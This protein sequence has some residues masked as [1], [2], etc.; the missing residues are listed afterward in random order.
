M[1]N[2]KTPVLKFW[3]SIFPTLIVGL[4]TFPN[5]AYG[6][7]SDSQDPILF[8]KGTPIFEARENIYEHENGEW[9]NF[10]E[11]GQRHSQI[12]PVEVSGLFLPYDALNNA[13]KNQSHPYRKIFGKIFDRLLPFNDFPSVYDWMSLGYYR[14]QRVGGIERPRGMPKEMRVGAGL[15]QTE[16]GSSLSF[17]CLSCHASQ[18][19]GTTVIGL[20]NKWPKANELFVLAKKAIPLV[21]A[22]LFRIATQGNEKDEA[23]FRRTQKNL[24]RVR[25]IEPIS[26]GVDTSLAQVGRALAT[27]KE[28]AWAEPSNFFERFPRRTVFSK[29]RSDSKPMP[30]WNVK[31]KNRWLADGSVVS[32]N[33]IITNLLWNEIGRG[34]D[35][36]ELEAWMTSNTRVIEE[37][38][39]LVFAN[40]APSY[41]DFA[42]VSRFDLAS[43]KRGEIIFK[44]NC[45]TC[46]GH[47]EKNWNFPEA[48]DLADQVKTKKVVYHEQTP[49]VNVGSEGGRNQ[50]MRDLESPLN[51]LEISQRFEVQIE[52]QEGY[53]PPPLVGIFSR[54]PYL[55]NASIPNLCELLTPANLRVK[56]FY[57]GPAENWSTD[58]DD[59]CVGYPVGRNVPQGW[60]QEKSWQ[61]HTNISGRKSIG[62]DQMLFN[63]NGIEKFSP[64]NKKDLISFLKTL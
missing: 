5:F 64:Q 48:S 20:P 19:F 21:P 8:A 11:A 1:P 45:S 32:G 34:T 63:R 47:Y 52:S 44:Q 60:T 16:W 4:W 30:W 23:L 29:I 13:L 62:H 12:Y 41:F 42:D 10:I 7:Q 59:D 18:F 24:H 3:K 49:V 15:L 43:A 6:M 40:Q 17:S 31:F 39:T 46:H 53:V 9:Q 57:A 33:P 28:N 50:G 26:L 27:R 56:D 51:S 55:H 2:A 38:T 14:D 37:L 58:F 61:V 54:Y 36:K 22:N 35:L 25:P